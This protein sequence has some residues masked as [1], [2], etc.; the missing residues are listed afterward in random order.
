MQYREFQPHPALRPFVE[1]Y[2]QLQ[3]GALCEALVVPD[4]NTG[5][6][7]FSSRVNRIDSRKEAADSF[8]NLSVVIG[9]KSRPVFYRFN[10]QDQLPAFGIRFRPAGLRAFTKMPMAELKDQAVEARDVFGTIPEHLN[11]A[12]FH[13]SDQQIIRETI[14]RFL[15]QNLLPRQARR[16]IS[17]QMV[18][19]IYCQRGQFHAPEWAK[20]FGVSERQAERLFQQY[21]GLAPKTFARV[22]R[23]NHAVLD[24]RD[25]KPKNLTELAYANGYFDQMHFVKEVKA[26][27]QNTPRR[28]L[29]YSAETW[30]QLLLN[31][32]SRRFDG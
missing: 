5:L 30:S 11:E 32:L 9:Q 24:Y 13:T 18:R 3:T 6:M 20:H 28:Y 4:G 26:F 25:H 19:R 15:F 31:M 16:E 14:D 21:V 2:W 27:T 12:I 29:Q 1:N 17:S 8:S 10:P 7:F 22:V 23:F